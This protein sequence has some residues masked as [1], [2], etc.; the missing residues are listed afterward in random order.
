MTE[1]P[2]AGEDDVPAEVPDHVDPASAPVE[3]TPL[4]EDTSEPADPGDAAELEWLIRTG[5]L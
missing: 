4:D 1:Q 5:G 3:P 2:G